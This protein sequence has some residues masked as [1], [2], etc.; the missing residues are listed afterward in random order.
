VHVAHHLR[1]GRQRSYWPIATPLPAST[2]DD[3][4]ILGGGTMVHQFS[5][6]GGPRMAAGGSIVLKRHT[7]HTLLA[8]PICGAPRHNVR[9]E[10][11][12]FGKEDSGQSL[13]RAYKVILIAKGLTPERSIQHAGNRTLLTCQ[14]YTVDGIAAPAIAAHFADRVR[15]TVRNPDPASP[16]GIMPV[17]PFW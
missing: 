4:R 8:T 12:G 6:I 14:K 9:P 10:T 7:R 15:L 3:Y 11:R 16:F 13:R 17:K 5:H 2:V 1:A